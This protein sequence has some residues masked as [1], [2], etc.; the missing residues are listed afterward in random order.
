[1][2]SGTPWNH[3]ITVW[4]NTY[5][6]PVFDA[7]YNYTMSALVTRA[8]PMVVDVTGGSQSS[9]TIVQQWDKSAGLAS[10][11][12]DFVSLGGSNFKIV[13]NANSG[14][15]LDAGTGAQSAAVTIP[16]CNGSTAQNFSVNPMPAKYGTFWIK[17]VIGNRCLTVSGTGGTA[18]RTHGQP[19][20][21]T[22][23]V[24]TNSTQQMV[25]QAVALP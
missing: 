23:C 15:C 1:M 3:V 11:Q 20:I 18:Q 2:N 14:K 8:N 12:F 13:M 19:M 16:S 7:G 22:D 9:G 24:S 21:V 17:N 5:F 6:T 25:I 10:S 4:R